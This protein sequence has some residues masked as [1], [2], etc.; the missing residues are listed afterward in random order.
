MYVL[1]T[2][3]ATGIGK[4][5]AAE[6]RSI[7]GTDIVITGRTESALQATA[8][9]LDISYVVCDHRALKTY[10]VPRSAYLRISM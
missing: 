2:G 1:I 3:G 7:A 5:I 9:E 4:A 10:R 8:A 6:F